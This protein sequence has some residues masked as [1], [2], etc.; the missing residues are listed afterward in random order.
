MADIGSYYSYRPMVRVFF[1]FF[2]GFL[3]TLTFHQLALEVLH[4]LHIFPVPA[5]NMTPVPPLGVPSVISLAFWGGVWGIPFALILPPP[6][7]SGVFV[8][9][10]FIVLGAIFPTAAFWWL[11]LPLKGH[12]AGYGFHYP[13]V[14]IGPIVNAAWGLGTA[15]FL[16]LMP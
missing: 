9:L 8:W 14:I 13:G 15:V 11:V 5:Y 2:A 6:A 1:G 3:A 16:C 10:A 12:P 7:Q 4:V